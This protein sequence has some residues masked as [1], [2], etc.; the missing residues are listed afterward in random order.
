MGYAELQR[1]IR[2]YVASAGVVQ[3]CLGMYQINGRP[4]REILDENRTLCSG[5]LHILYTQVFPAQSGKFVL[6]L[7]QKMVSQKRRVLLLAGIG[8]HNDFNVDVVWKVFA[9]P[10]AE[11]V[12]KRAERNATQIPRSLWPKLVWANPH[13]PGLLKTPI[14]PSQSYESVQNFIKEMTSRLQLYNIP[15]FDTFNMTAPIHSTD[16]THY[17]YGA[18]MAKVHILINWIK[19]RHDRS[20]W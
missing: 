6:P 1:Y 12:S 4:C 3:Q 13:A 8:I 5:T 15:I 7:L 2:K 19:E 11:Y 9:Q 16:G 14:V 20:D 10:L 18:N 17:G